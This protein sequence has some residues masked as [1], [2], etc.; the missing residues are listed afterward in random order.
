MSRKVIWAAIAAGG[1]SIALL[2]PATSGAAK[3]KTIGS[4]LQG[5]PA[6]G[7][8]YG[9]G[10]GPCAIQQISLPG[11]PH[12]TRAPFKGKIR[13]WRFR[14]TDEDAEGSYGLR[15]AVV[16]EV[17]SAA[18]GG[19]QPVET[20]FRVVR[21]SGE[22]QVGPE[23]GTYK[24][25][26]RLKVKKGDF[27]ALEPP[28]GPDTPIVDEFYVPHP[29][30]LAYEWFPFPPPGGVD[31]PSGSTNNVEYFYNATIK[32]KKKKRR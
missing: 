14:T 15:L 23:P 28:Y 2:A 5:T 3:K 1:L 20:R 6:P 18:S 11:D 29:G 26:A 10:T 22:R 21:H 31:N 12:A 9:C 17:G 4:D 32:K 8:G 24:F 19:G 7:S 16:R 13:K 30:A 27:I 25:K